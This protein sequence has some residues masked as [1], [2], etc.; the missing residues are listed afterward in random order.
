MFNHEKSS[1]KFFFFNASLNW[2]KK[3]K[4]KIK[5]IFLL[6]GFLDTAG[7]RGV[8]DTVELDSTVIMTLSSLTPGCP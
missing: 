7:L 5:E 3:T 2:R 6:H 8:S 1:V 4:R